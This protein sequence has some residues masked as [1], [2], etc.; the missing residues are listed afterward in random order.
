MKLSDVIGK[1]VEIEIEFG[2]I[3][4]GQVLGFENG[5]VQVQLDDPAKHFGRGYR[6]FD[7]SEIK[8]IV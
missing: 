1:R 2:E 5:K 6:T 4:Q 3:I 7:I 8:Q